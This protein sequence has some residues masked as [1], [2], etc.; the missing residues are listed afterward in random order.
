MESRGVIRARI[1][2]H[3]CRKVNPGS[4]LIPIGVGEVLGRS[5]ALSE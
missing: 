4:E 5:F 1:A 3:R 2:L